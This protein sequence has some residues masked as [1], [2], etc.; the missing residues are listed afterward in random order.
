M[1]KNNICCVGKWLFVNNQEEANV[2]CAV[3]QKPL[4]VNVGR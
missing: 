4:G 2:M 3:A 1:L